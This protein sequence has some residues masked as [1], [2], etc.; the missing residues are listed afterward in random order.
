MSQISKENGPTII[1]SQQSRHPEMTLTPPVERRREQQE[2]ERIR[3][4]CCFCP[5]GGLWVVGTHGDTD[6]EKIRSREGQQTPESDASQTLPPPSIQ[7][8]KQLAP[9]QKVSL[10]P[11]LA[12][13]PLFTPLPETPGSV[14]QVRRLQT[15]QEHERSNL[16]ARKP[17]TSLPASSQKP[18]LSPISESAPDRRTLAKTLPPQVHPPDLSQQPRQG[19]RQPTLSGPTKPPGIQ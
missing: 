13:L 17:A 10:P 12:P 18:G 1:S 9:L 19:S 6:E 3:G 7:S 2:A 5:G 11:Q 14:S 15:S 16:P 8:R 4:G